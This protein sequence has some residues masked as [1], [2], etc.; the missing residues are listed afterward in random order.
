MAGPVSANDA[1]V[2][3]ALDVLLQPV[4]QRMALGVFVKKYLPFLSL[5][6]IDNET[7]KRMISIIESKTGATHSRSDLHSN[8]LNEWMSDVGSPFVEVEIIDSE[9]QLVYVVPP[10]LNNDEELVENANSL[11]V[12]VEQASLQGRVLPESA[13]KYIQANIIPLIHKPQP[14]QK[15]IDMWN[16]IYR[17]HGLPLYRQ[18]Q[19]DETGAVIPEGRDKEGRVVVENLDDFDD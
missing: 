12:L 18:T 15:H 10:F 5:Q 6:P 7:I 17:Y 9:G 11:P 8:L 3:Q 19:T 16:T 14:S 1:Q 2:L 13:F 4:R